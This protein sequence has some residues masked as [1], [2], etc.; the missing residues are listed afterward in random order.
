MSLTF[1]DREYKSDDLR[2]ESV[3]LAKDLAKN[4]KLEQPLPAGVDLSEVEQ[5][6]I[7]AQVCLFFTPW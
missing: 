1:L 5:N 3:L 6:E 7:Q 4:A 2:R